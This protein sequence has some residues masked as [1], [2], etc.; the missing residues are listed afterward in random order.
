MTSADALASLGRA[1]A[2]VARTTTV[3]RVAD[4]VPEEVVEARLRPGERLPEQ[5]VCLALADSRNTA[6]EASSPSGCRCA[7]PTTACASPGPTAPPQMGLLLAEMRL[8]LHRARPP[9]VLRAPRGG[10]L[11]IRG[12][13]LGGFAPGSARERP[14]RPGRV[15]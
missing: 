10:H 3:E 13:L 12:R 6:R 5:D 8:V 9:R 1:R 11:D 7:R 14:A 2:V 15:P 4:A